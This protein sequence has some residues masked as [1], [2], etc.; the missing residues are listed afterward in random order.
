MRVPRLE[1]LAKSIA[2]FRRALATVVVLVFMLY[3]I[4]TVR[5]GQYGVAP[6]RGETLRARVFLSGESA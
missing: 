5:G 6:R 3:N 2:K 4:A 1:A